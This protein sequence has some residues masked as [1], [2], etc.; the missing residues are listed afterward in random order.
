MA[1]ADQQYAPL[2]AGNRLDIT[3]TIT[4]SNW[5]TGRLDLPRHR[6]LVV[7]QSRAMRTVSMG[8][9]SKKN[10]VGWS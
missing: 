6:R 5:G 4:S 2:S 3:Q 10:A 7:L 8:V 1:A 9:R